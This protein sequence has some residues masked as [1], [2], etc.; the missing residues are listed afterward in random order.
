MPVFKYNCLRF[1]PFIVVLAAQVGNVL[2]KMS[3]QLNIKTC[4]FE[5]QLK[6]N[7]QI[8]ELHD[9]GFSTDNKRSM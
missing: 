6:S 2:W 1:L 8:Q 4:V 9:A 3:N 5:T 7:V